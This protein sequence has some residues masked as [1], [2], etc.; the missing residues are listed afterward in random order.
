MD[1]DVFGEYLPLKVEYK[2]YDG[3]DAAEIIIPTEINLSFTQKQQ[4]SKGFSVSL[5]FERFLDFS[6][7]L[8]EFYVSLFSAGAKKLIPLLILPFAYIA[9]AFKTLYVSLGRLKDREMR[10]RLKSSSHLRQ[11]IKHIRLMTLKQ[12]D[13]NKTAYFFKSLK[14]YIIASLPEEKQIIKAVFSYAFPLTVI[15]VMALSL[16]GSNRIFAIRV[17]HG[18]KTVGYVENQSV[19]NES[20]DIIYDKLSD[21]KGYS[22]LFKDITFSLERVDV[23]DLSSADMMSEAILACSSYGYKRACGIYIDGTFLCAIPNESDALSVFSSVLE[24]YEKRA[25]SST[26][27]GFVE[28]I[29]YIQGYY[30]QDSDMVWDS[31]KLKEHLSEDG[32]PVRVKV[33]KTSTKTETLKYETVKKN[34]SSLYK[35]TKKTTQKGKNGK[36]Q[37]TELTTYIDSKK[38]YTGVV[39][40]V[41]IKEPVDEVVL[42]GTKSNSSASS[43]APSKSFIWP[44]RG[45]YSISSYYGYRSAS[46]SGWSYHGGL[47]IVLGYGSSAGIPVVAS[48]SGTV[49]TA[50]SGWRGYGHTVVIDHGNGIKT[51]YAHMYP[52]SIAVSV[53]QKVYQ[54]Q[55]IGRIGSTGNSTGPHLHFEVLVNGYKVNPLPYIR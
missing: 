55:Q 11:D 38:A 1:K 34:T 39:S 47:D 33:M 10:K 7:D 51:R 2:K 14:S 21:E 16:L 18:G 52:G 24:P 20:K 54:G 23:S 27:V 50:Y 8:G 36:V 30:P 19:Y 6:E 28:E 13:E 43:Y 42:I 37:V 15:A 5:L 44:T 17:M 22:E 9:G 41:V 4:K 35:G 32:S 25:D 40:E 49:V 45:A 29:E 48:A 31:A 53:G 46:I 3:Q 26:T 12:E